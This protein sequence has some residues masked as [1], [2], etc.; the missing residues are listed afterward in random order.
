MNAA[1][2]EEYLQRERGRYARRKETGSRKCVKDMT[3][4]EHR[5]QKHAWKRD[6]RVHREHVKTAPTVITPPRSP[7]VVADQAPAPPQP[8]N[9]ARGRRKVRRDRS[10]AYRTINKLTVKLETLE[11]SAKR[12][13]K[14]YERAQKKIEK[15]QPNTPRSKARRLLKLVDNNVVRKRLVMS[16]F[17]L[18]ALR[19][20]YQKCRTNKDR[21][22]DEETVGWRLISSKIQVPEESGLNHRF[23]QEVNV[24]N[25][26]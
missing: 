13:Q 14:R 19:S 3:P 8:S 5:R 17:V 11:R 16:N 6:Q 22:F 9:A 20:M 4:R 25:Q 23:F 18:S 15:F 10:K 21:Q 2:H 1:A 24:V 26:V 12:I 7:G